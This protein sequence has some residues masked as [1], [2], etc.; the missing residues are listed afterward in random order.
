MPTV[1]VGTGQLQ[2]EHVLI[3]AQYLDSTV[4]EHQHWALLIMEES[5]ARAESKKTADWHFSKLHSN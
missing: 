1:I 3:G 2:C 4:P 5:E